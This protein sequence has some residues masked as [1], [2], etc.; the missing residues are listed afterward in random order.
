M[1]P[2]IGDMGGPVRP[3]EVPI[4]TCQ[5]GR[6][7]FVALII[8]L[9]HLSLRIAYLHDNRVAYRYRYWIH[10]MYVW[11]LKCTFTIPDIGITD[12]D[13]FGAPS[14]SWNFGSTLKL[15]LQPIWEA[16]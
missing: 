10:S 3:L 7:P 5:K 13:N 12:V 14:D 1:P 16:F 11:P 9:T 8:R 6:V 4:S 2:V 15:T